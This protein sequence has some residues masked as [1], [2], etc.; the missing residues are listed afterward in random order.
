MVYRLQYPFIPEDRL[1][2]LMADR[3]GVKLAAATMARMSAKG[4]E[5]F[6][7]FV[8]AVC[9]FVKTAAVKQL[10]ETGFRIGGNT[11]WLHVVV[12]AW[13]SFYRVSPKRGR[14]LE[15][16]IGIVV[17]DHWKPD[18]TREGVQHALCNAPHLRELQALVE[19]EKEPWARRMQRLL[20]RACHATPLA[21][22]RD[23]PLKPRLVKRFQRRDDAIVAEG[24][25]FHEAQPPLT[26]QGSP[27]KRRGRPPAAP[28]ITFCCA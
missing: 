13:L 23:G 18:Y 10:D 7:G 15:G 26:A 6:Q 19:I 9:Q 25:A 11:P 27:R 12:T 1:V 4:V 3:F 2:E 20:R 21:R 24:T 17:H 28:A 16:L 14:L 22:E 8:D 5:R